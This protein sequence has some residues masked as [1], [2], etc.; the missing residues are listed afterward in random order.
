MDNDLL[1][2][3]GQ[4]ATALAILTLVVFTFLPILETR[5]YWIRLLDFPRLQFYSALCVFL[6]IWAVIGWENFAG[7]MVFVL[8]LA[9]VIYQFGV[10]WQY[11]PLHPVMADSAPEGAT[12]DRLRILVMNVQKEN[13]D[14]QAVEDTIAREN[15]DILLLME[16][17]SWWVR[18]LAHLEDRF[19]H[20]SQ[21][22]PEASSYY[23]MQVYSNLPLV[24]SDIMYPFS[25]DVPMF[26]G[27]FAHPAGNITFIGVHPRPPLDL[28]H[29]STMRDATI[30]HAAKIAAE[31]T[32]Q[33]IVAGDFNA[34]PWERTVRRALRV[35]RLLDPRVGRSVHASFHVRNPLMRWPLDQILWQPGPALLRYDVLPSVGSDHYPVVADLLLNAG[36]KGRPIDPR[37]DDKPLADMAFAAAYEME[38]AGGD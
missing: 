23:G 13:R 30:L 24:Q 33:V 17:N 29:P 22:I 5:T 27:E 11:S 32:G 6:G 2:M 14:S 28:K 1:M 38:E 7:V 25:C 3:L 26:M 31:R 34:T 35:G 9:A 15:P 12:G 16:T 18:K 36:A 10:L 21:E 37:P 20:R 8:G 19:H 4:G